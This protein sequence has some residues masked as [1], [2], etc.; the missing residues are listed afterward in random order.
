MLAYCRSYSCILRFPEM[1]NS[2]EKN[3]ICDKVQQSERAAYVNDS[4]PLMQNLIVF[5][6]VD[7]PEPLQPK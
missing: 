7:T 3:L 2:E 4:Q 1:T 6:N 5:F